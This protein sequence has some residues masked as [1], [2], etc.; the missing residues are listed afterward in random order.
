MMSAMNRSL[1]GRLLELLVC[2][3]DIAE[4]V[5]RW[6]V[7]GQEFDTPEPRTDVAFCGPHYPV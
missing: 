2:R 4:R 3:D 7:Y 5:L 1:E 6:L